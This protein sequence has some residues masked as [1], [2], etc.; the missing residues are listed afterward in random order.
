MAEEIEKVIRGLHFGDR[1]D[2]YW[3]DA[4]EVSSGK[5]SQDVETHVH[6]TGFYLGTK[7]RKRRHLVLAKEIIDAGSA[8]HYNVILFSMIDRIDVIQHDALDPRL[9]RTLRKFVK[10]SIEGLNEKDGWAYEENDRPSKRLKRVPGS[11]PGG[12]KGK[13]QTK[14]ERIQSLEVRVAVLEDRLKYQGFLEKVIWVLLATSLG[15][16]VLEALK[17]IG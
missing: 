5:P 14:D 4:S 13:K 9:K 2:V 10:R 7:G 15:K 3:Y 11:N 1:I 12:K 8:Y 17:V 6:S 16:L